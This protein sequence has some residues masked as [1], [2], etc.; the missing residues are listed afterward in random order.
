MSR[1]DDY[2]CCNHGCNHGRSCPAKPIRTIKPYPAVPPDDDAQPH[3]PGGLLSDMLVG[4]IQVMALLMIA[5]AVAA[6][7]VVVTKS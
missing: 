2:Y 6:I 5:M 7:V 3:S 4:F 1:D